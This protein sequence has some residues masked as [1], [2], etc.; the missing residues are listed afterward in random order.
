MLTS[1]SVSSLIKQGDMSVKQ[2]KK[3]KVKLIK[4][5]RMKDVG[6]VEPGKVLEVD[7]HF[8]RELIANE[9]ATDNLEAKTAD[10]KKEAAK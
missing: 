4:A 7:E 2:P 8:A 9:K 3:M 5:I 1:D 10:P 6:R